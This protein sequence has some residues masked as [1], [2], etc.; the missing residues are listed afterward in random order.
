M[1]FLQRTLKSEILN[2][3][4]K[5]R[6]S[7]LLCDDEVRWT[8]QDILLR[9]PELQELI[10]AASAEGESIGVCFPNWAVQAFVILTVMTAGRVPVILSFS[11][12]TADPQ[13]WLQN[14]K[15]R[16]LLTAAGVEAQLQGQVRFATLSRQAR[17]EKISLQG[18]QSRGTGLPELLPKGTGLVLYTSG[19][20]GVPKGIA[21]PE[22]GI[23]ETTEYLISYFNLNQTTVAP[24]ILPI[25]HS[26]ALNTQFFP[27][28]F[29][30]GLC[31]FTNSRLSIGRIYRTLLAEKGTF[32]SLISEVLRTCWDE[33]NRKNLPAAEQVRHV[34][35]AGGMISTK[36]LQM[37]NELFPNALIHKG[38]GLTEAIRVSMIHHKQVNFHSN[39]VGK[40]LPFVQVEIRDAGNVLAQPEAVG[41]IF[42]KG[43]NV[44]LGFSRQNPGG[45]FS[46]GGIGT[47]GFLATGDIGC[48]NRDGQICILGR[49]DGLYKINGHRVSGFEIEK[50]AL[51]YSD[52]IR[53]AKCTIVEDQLRHGQKMVLMLE[54][55]TDSQKKFIDQD[56]NDVR[57]KIWEKFKALS[58]FP[59]EVIILGKFPRTANGKVDLKKLAGLYSSTFKESLIQHSRS[60]LHFYQIPNEILEGALA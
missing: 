50:I 31:S 24:I 41:E 57:H 45:V 28:F 6:T 11:D 12:L 47:D 38:Y 51:E 37:A 49:E 3:L 19:S 48:W 29:A 33:K 5:Q 2:T 18:D 39:A 22:I 36:A 53:N 42:V 25:C 34:Q 60:N 26:M 4:Q 52:L 7:L 46:A 23:L 21:V 27:T 9:M 13:T 30:G 54:I 10:L 55:Q 43:P 44:M 14:A 16:V 32:I 8:G 59:K 40:P 56:L 15:V 58:Y 17:I 20:T 1:P 35:L